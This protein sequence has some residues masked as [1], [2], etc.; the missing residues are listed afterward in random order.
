MSDGVSP[1][2]I[3]SVLVSVRDLDRSATFYRDVLSLHEVLREDLVA[4]LSRDPDGTFALYLR[5]A[6][7]DAIRTGQQTLGI[8]SFSYDV[9]SLAEL[10]QVE[11]RLR[12]IDAFQ[13]RLRLDVGEVVI[14]HDP[15]RLPLTLIALKT[16][17]ISPDDYHHWLARI[18]T[19]DL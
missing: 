6:N 7:H 4:V 15:D 2:S 11:G 3:R 16:G 14:G 13:E 18:Y 9:G 5:R 1:G 19:M 8:R 10:D 17:R 12:A